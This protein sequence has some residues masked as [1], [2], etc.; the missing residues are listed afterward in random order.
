MK[1]LLKRTFYA[2]LGLIAL[3]ATYLFVI[4]NSEKFATD[5]AYL[6]CALDQV[7]SDKHDNNF[8]DLVRNH[9]PKY[10]VGRLREDWIENKVLLTWVADVG[11]SENGLDSKVKL[12]I[13]TNTYSG[14]SYDGSFT[15]GTQRTF[16]RNTLLYTNERKPTSTAEVDHWLTRKCV[17]VDKSIYEEK[18]KKSAAAT[19]AKQTI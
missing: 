3:G 5:I 17:I 19:K 8:L 18:R 1:K 15:F 4:S 9:H 13:S 14:F 2:T 16:D 7:G 6:E 11:D 10:I 12:N